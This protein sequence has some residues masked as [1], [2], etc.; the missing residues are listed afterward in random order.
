MHDGRFATLDA[1]IDHYSFGLQHS[2][3][4]DPLMKKISSGGIQLSVTEKQDLI[5]FLKT[6]S[7]NEF[8]TN[9]AYAA[10]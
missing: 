4:V 5:A 7:D 9:S 6:F 10:E 2:N 1:V 8:N 3:T